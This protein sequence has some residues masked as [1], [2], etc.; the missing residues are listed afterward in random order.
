MPYC[1]RHRQIHNC[2][3]M[4]Q[5][6]ITTVRAQ[7]DDFQ[8]PYSKTAA[9]RCGR[10]CC[11]SLATSC[12]EGK[13]QCRLLELV[14]QEP[15]P[16]LQLDETLTHSVSSLVGMS[17]GGSQPPHAHFHLTP[18][19]GVPPQRGEEA[20]GGRCDLVS[21]HELDGIRHCG[22]CTKQEGLFRSAASSS[23]CHKTSRMHLMQIKA[24]QVPRVHVRKHSLRTVEQHAESNCL[25]CLA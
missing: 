2:C 19:A 5:C 23:C 9:S 21:H 18:V 7:N 15:I 24:P 10:L 12:G 14:L 11:M 3:R 17:K 6:F 13:K 20:F 16:H 4:L 8:A 25:S 1:G 22:H